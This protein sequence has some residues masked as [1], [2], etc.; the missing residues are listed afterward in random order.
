MAKTDFEEKQEVVLALEMQLAD[1]KQQL[2]Q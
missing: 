1:A 2:A